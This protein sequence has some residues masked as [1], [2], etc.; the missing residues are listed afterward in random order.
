MIKYH[1][2]QETI[3]EEITNFKIDNRIAIVKE[4][5]ITELKNFEAEQPI[6]IQYT[7]LLFYYQKILRLR[8]C[9]LMLQS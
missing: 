8:N 5:Y 2:L 4:N 9:I 6:C 7:T 1:V 3:I